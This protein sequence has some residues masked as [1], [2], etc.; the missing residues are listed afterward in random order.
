MSMYKPLTIGLGLL[1]SANALQPGRVVP[2][3]RTVSPVGVSRREMVTG[4]GAAA[5]LAL[6]T[7]AFAED[8]GL[9]GLFE[10]STGRP[11]QAI[12]QFTVDALTSKPSSAIKNANAN[13]VAAVEASQAAALARREAIQD[14][15]EAREARLAAAK[16]AREAAKAARST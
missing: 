16:E 15:K 5:A 9:L 1:A 4:L 7:P 8:E 10:P 13:S 12:T 3:T 6:S 14:A 2:N 11:G